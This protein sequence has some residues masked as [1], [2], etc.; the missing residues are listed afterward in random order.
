MLTV[1]QTAV[2]DAPMS[3]VM[4][5]LNDIEHIPNWATVKGVI[6]N[7]HGSGVGMTYNWHYSVQGLHFDGRS[8]VL[9]Q[10]E[11]I[12]ITKTTGDVNS[13]WTIT[14]TAIAPKNTALNVVVEIDPP[15]KFVEVLADQIIQQYATP[16]VARENLMRFKQAVEQKVQLAE[17]T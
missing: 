7:V 15:N 17:Q 3:L 1:E 12:L 11:D 13:L 4:Q 9:E 14:L 2:I 6:D 5:V 16:Q 10:G 8:E